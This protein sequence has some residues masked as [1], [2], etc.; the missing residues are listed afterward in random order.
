[1]KKEQ[2]NL[3]SLHFLAVVWTRS[4]FGVLVESAPNNYFVDHISMMEHLMLNGIWKDRAQNMGSSWRA[5]E[6]PI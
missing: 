2:K 3:L 5:I 6:C 1:M 4:S